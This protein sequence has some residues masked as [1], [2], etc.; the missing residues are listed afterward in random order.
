MQFRARL[1]RVHVISGCA[2]FPAEPRYNLAGLLT[3]AATILDA[4]TK[5][6]DRRATWLFAYLTEILLS[7]LC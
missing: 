7:E 1:E 6:Y 3:P 2:T 4:S 5:I